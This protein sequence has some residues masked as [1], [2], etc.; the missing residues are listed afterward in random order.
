MLGRLINGHQQTDSKRRVKAQEHRHDVTMPAKPPGVPQI[1]EQEIAPKAINQA[2]Q[3]Q[4]YLQGA[5]TFHTVLRFVRCKVITNS[6]S[7][8]AIVSCNAF[9]YWTLRASAAAAECFSPS[10]RLATGTARPKERPSEHKIKDE[11]NQVGYEESGNHPNPSRHLT[12]CC[13]PINI[14][15]GKEKSRGEDAKR[16][17]KPKRFWHGTE[18]SFGSK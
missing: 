14:S 2:H 9:R 18:K 3:H 1:V 7:D 13:V 17:A 5:L 8:C 10:N 6:F 15:E 4:H 16:Q 11:S 12:P